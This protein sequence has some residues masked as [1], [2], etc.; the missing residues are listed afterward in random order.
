MLT[1]KQQAALTAILTHPTRAEAAR[2]AGIGDKTLY[3]YLCNPEFIREYRQAFTAMVEEATRAAQM[4]LIPALTALHE[5]CVD[6]G[7]PAMARISAARC[8]LDMGLKLTEMNDV[9]M[10]LE[11]LEDA[12][13]R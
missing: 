6:S 10:R 7:A 13:K 3:R 4:S 2:A 8:L 11:A 5:I 12:V 9:E 1:A